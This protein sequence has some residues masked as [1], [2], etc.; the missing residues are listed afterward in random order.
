MAGIPLL[1]R[2][3]QDPQRRRQ[4]TLVQLMRREVEAASSGPRGAG[5]AIRTGI[6]GVTA[7]AH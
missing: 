7:G 1:H 2:A 6:D 3:T 5:A 4:P